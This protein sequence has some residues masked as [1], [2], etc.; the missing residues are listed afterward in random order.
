[1]AALA[2]QPGHRGPGDA[3]RTVDYR[4]TDSDCGNVAV[5][6]DRTPRQQS[7][8]PQ[9]ATCIDATS[10]LL[11]FFF[12]FLSLLVFF[13]AIRHAVSAP[14]EGLTK[15]MLLKQNIKTNKKG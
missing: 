10:L 7:G 11:C 4:L 9:M 6:V 8:T 3:F 5:L 12:H 2:E 1:M 15:H 13:V 14:F